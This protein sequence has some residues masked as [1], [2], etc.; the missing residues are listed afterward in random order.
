VNKEDLFLI[1]QLL[2]ALKRKCL[3]GSLYTATI[4]GIELIKR[5]ELIDYSSY[6]D[7]NQILNHVVNC[8]E[9]RRAMKKYYS[10]QPNIP[11]KLKVEGKID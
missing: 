2:I 4:K 9:C 5:E 7:C 6:E 3:T 11:E 1:E 10:V 8:K